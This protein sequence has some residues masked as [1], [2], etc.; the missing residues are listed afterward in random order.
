M[1]SNSLQPPPH[2]ATGACDE[3]ARRRGVV[4][5]L[6]LSALVVAS[7]LAYAILAAA[8]LEAQS[9]AHLRA[10]VQAELMAENG[11]NTAMHYLL[12]PQESPV[13]L[14]EGM[15]GDW[16]YPGQANVAMGED[17]FSVT[18]IN[19]SPGRFRIDGYGRSRDSD[20]ALCERHLRV[21]V[22]GVSDWAARGA[23]QF[24]SKVKLDPD[25]TVVGDV[26]VDGDYEGGGAISGVR[27]ASNHV[28]GDPSWGAPPIHPEMVVPPFDGLN[29]VRAIQERSGKYV[30]G[31]ST[32]KVD[33]ILF[34]PVLL[35]P[36]AST[37]NPGRVFAYV[38]T[39]PLTLGGLAAA[40]FNGTLVVTQ[41]DVVITQDWTF[42]PQPS[43]PAL[44]VSG[45][46]SLNGG[47]GKLTVNGVYY[48]GDSFGSSNTTALSPVTVNG[49]LLCATSSGTTFGSSVP[50]ALLFNFD[51]VKAD[52]PDLT[53]QGIRY[54]R[55][56]IE[57]WEQMN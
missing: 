18:V 14:V 53:D 48:S 46:T 55:L 12:Q 4:L 13:A 50:G 23:L 15:A 36:L 47:S 2:R 10:A 17:S 32:C 3:R 28:T 43:M 37:H 44:L 20:G 25:V 21:H 1:K 39:S 51:A 40:T 41:A 19:L 56:Q 49:S 29:L 26:V 52:V 27:Y 30:Y 24:A 42:N 22:V 35:P 34:S 9:S 6:V 16:H 31:N 33:Y 5:L 57:D 38:G 7:I 11:V 45:K 8:S 54:T